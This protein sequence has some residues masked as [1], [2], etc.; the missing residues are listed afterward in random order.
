M[1]RGLLEPWAPS[2]A[3]DRFE[4]SVN[5]RGSFR[6]ESQAAAAHLVSLLGSERKEPEENL[7]AHKDSALTTFAYPEAARVHWWRS[8]VESG[9]RS[10]ALT[11]SNQPTAILAPCQHLLEIIQHPRILG[12]CR[13]AD[14]I[15]GMHSV[16]SN[17]AS[18]MSI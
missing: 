6:Q 14:G 2:L 13:L 10:H 7:A 12:H 17:M 9:R 11:H 1:D 3:C 18:F 4:E 16:C 8:V 5:C 15:R